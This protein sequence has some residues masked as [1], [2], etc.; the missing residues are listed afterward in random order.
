[1]N[2]SEDNIRKLLEMLDN[3]DAYSE[4]EIR[5]IIDR[6]EET[7]ETYRMMVDIKCSSRRKSDDRP[8]DVDA[9]WKQFE[10]AH[11]STRR[12]RVWMKIAAGFVGF[13]FVSGLSFATV[14]I[15][16]HH[17][18][19]HESEQAVRI[20]SAETQLPGINAGSFGV[21]MTGT[22]TLVCLQLSQP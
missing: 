18:E 7:R 21:C 10:D 12:Q 8:V 20:A 13:L 2:N 22:E 3:P 5:D 17:N 9:A 6:D 11:Y 19:R 16:R 15:L 14:T 4:Q 1:M